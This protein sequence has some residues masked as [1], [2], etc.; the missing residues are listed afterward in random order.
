MTA[1]VP[2]LY[3][4]PKLPAW[5]DWGVIVLTAFSLLLL[6]AESSVAAESVE[7]HWLRWIDTAVCGVFVLDFAVRFARA[8]KR[9]TF[10]KRN[11]FDLLGAIPLVGPL[12]TFR[13]V[14]LIRILRFTRV[15]TLARRLMR[16]FDVAM[17]SQTFGYLGAIA[18]IVWLTAAF[19]F[20]GFESGVNESVRGIDDALW[21][22]MTTLSTVGYGDLYPKTNGGRVVAFTTMI[23]GVGVLG[24][25]AATIATAFIDIRE[26]G[27]KGLR[28][29]HMEDHLLVLGWNPKAATAIKNFRLD[30][31]HEATKIVIV[32]DVPESPF[33]DPTV[34][35]VRGQPGKREVLDRASASGAAVAI[36]FASDPKD[37]RSDHETALVVLAL[38]EL[39]PSVHVSAELVDPEQREFLQRA[40]CD[41]VVD[42]QALASALLARSAQDPGV[43]DVLEDLLTNR[44]GSEI[45]RVRVGPDHV[46]RSF[47]EY[48]L[49]MLERDC[50]VIGL[51]RGRTHMINPK[52]STRVQDGDH[53]F[54]VA[55]APP[56]GAAAK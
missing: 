4:E 3:V 37:P 56:D 17:P 7:G 38:R 48:C 18:V 39:S 54:V 20:Y 26:R 27:K 15:I 19:V 11:W 29:Y 5:W 35:F 44:G 32:A 33:D 34:K 45:Y 23:F 13:V 42:S 12:R 52:G 25:L 55:D 46:G 24:T 6:V 9:W 43:G 8:D 53:A 16:R 50:T 1:R 49:A 28:S 31:R 10:V 14:R 40:G 2:S 36:V 30:P 41:G 22:S 51:A 47:R 21:W